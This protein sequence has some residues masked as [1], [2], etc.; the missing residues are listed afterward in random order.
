MPAL[1]IIHPEDPLLRQIYRTARRVSRYFKVRL[2]DVERIPREGAALLVGNHALMG[3]DT[4]A[5]L[6]ELFFQ[7]QR[8]PR[9]MGLRALFKIPL[10]RRLLRG[11]GMASGDRQTAISL[12]KRGEL[13]LTYPGGARDSLKSQRERYKLKWEGRL[14]FAHAAIASGAP[15]IPVAGVGPDECFPVLGRTPRLRLP[16]LTARPE[17]VPLFVPIARRVPF[18]FFIGEPIAPPTLPPSAS[19]AM[20]RDAAADF[21]V[22]VRDALE[23]LLMEGVQRRVHVSDAETSESHDVGDDAALLRELARRLVKDALAASAFRG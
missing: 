2:H 1:K 22:E 5:L 14:G 23:A 10:V 18:H 16:G 3:V 11:V 9:G 21:A 17:P 4:W 19:P 6:P 8:V 20:I 12:L 15:V 13:V 7:T